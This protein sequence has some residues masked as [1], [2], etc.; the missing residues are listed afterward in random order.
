MPLLDV[1]L[2]TKSPADVNFRIDKDA[3]LP[4]LRLQ[5]IDQGSV[6]DFTGGAVTFSM[7]N[8][9]GTAKII[10]AVAVLE[11]PATDGII[12][13]EWAAADT[14]TDDIFI[15]QFKVVVGTRQYLVPNNSAERL[16]IL[17]GAV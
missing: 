15:G 9:Q 2:E 6:V 8:L 10:N 5:V 4:P 11:S 17:I 14:D 16:R 12:K 1:F 7:E 13:Y 3:T